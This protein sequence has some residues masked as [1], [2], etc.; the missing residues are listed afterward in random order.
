MLFLSRARQDELFACRSSL[1]FQE[2]Q[3]RSGQIVVAENETCTWFPQHPSFQEWMRDGRG[4]LWLQ[5][6]PGAGKSTIMKHA[7]EWT[8]RQS[9]KKP[10]V[11]AFF[12]YGL[13][14]DL[15]KTLLGLYC[16]LIRQLIPQIPFAFLP[17]LSHMPEEPGPRA[18]GLLDLQAHLKQAL[19]EASKTRQ[20]VLFID[21]LDE[22]SKAE[23]DTLLALLG[24][25]CYDEE[26]AGLKVNICVSC[27]YHPNLFTQGVII[28]AEENN[29][30]DIATFVRQEL[31]DLPF[32]KKVPLG[33]FIIPRSNGLFQWAG[34]VC[35]NVRDHH[36]S[37]KP[38]EKIL[39]LIEDIPQDLHALYERL[40]KEMS[41]REM[42]QSLKLFRWVGF[43][44]RMISLRELQHA[45]VLAPDMKGRSIE[46]YSTSED[47]LHDLDD[48]INSVKYY[49][50]GLIG[51]EAAHKLDG[52]QA[53]GERVRLIHASVMDYLCE[54]GLEFLE[55][56]IGI[57]ST[58][59]PE[60]TAHYY[61][62]RCCLRYMFMRG[63]R[64]DFD[65]RQ[66]SSSR[67]P[68]DHYVQSAI[69]YHFNKAEEYGVE[70]F[71]LLEIFG[72]PNETA[73]MASFRAFVP[74][75]NQA[76]LIHVLAAC[77][78]MSAI[79]P[80]IQYSGEKD[81]SKYESEIYSLLSH[82]EVRED[83]LLPSGR[84]NLDIRNSI[85]M[86]PLHFALFFDQVDVAHEL[87]NSN[88]VDV[89]AVK[90][91]GERPLHNA[92]NKGHSSIVRELLRNTT[93]NPNAQD[94]KGRTALHSAVMGCKEEVIAIL[95]EDCRVNV[96]ARNKDG[97]TP[98]HTAIDSGELS[99]VEPLLASAN[100]DVNV[101]EKK[102]Q[103]PLIFFMVAYPGLADE[104]EHGEL[105][106]VLLALLRHP[107]IDT[108]AKDKMQRTALFH[109]AASGLAI[110]VRVLVD[111]GVRGAGE[112][113]KLG[114]TPLSQ[115]AV[116][117]HLEIVRRLL[118]V[119]EL[120]EDILQYA[121]QESK[122]KGKVD[123][124][125]C[126]VETGK[127]TET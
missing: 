13:G 103:S 55:G 122:K 36:R 3:V 90:S 53:W 34:V 67:F 111:H 7:V 75:V 86:T 8:Q 22:F 21:A 116:K 57:S 32:K 89:N 91:Q 54:R 45:W 93:V 39:R 29:G 46:E 81:G 37:G 126:L 51:F 28:R 66:E 117:G 109:A 119:E 56:E 16:S 72:W 63:T 73:A 6:L 48:L 99:L 25:L 12:I 106:N 114:R 107:K 100:I 115:A 71:E 64:E 68:L 113:D 124:M 49:S 60:G 98:L 82:G 24:D 127:I 31:R 5:G 41:G 23:I 83:V 58:G 11:A 104:S 26:S 61:V 20:T 44:E 2:E 69:L 110:Y 30:Q 9:T 108:H 18:W 33:E 123:I 125:R 80:L 92:A 43:S 59:H 38:L 65:T 96:N 120:E 52:D 17:M 74:R 88:R 19:R 77:G 79:R 85:A 84:I 27:R 118:A 97:E 78:V 15:Q 42:E 76:S 1:S 95:L 40:F 112:K 35:Q 62:S 101:K 70:Q 102:G 50:K 10:A 105:A 94:D 87:L 47:F 14:M 4:L 121:Y